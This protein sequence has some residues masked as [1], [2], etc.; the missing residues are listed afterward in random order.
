MNFLKNLL[1][2]GAMFAWWIVALNYAGLVNVNIPMLQWDRENVVF[3]TQ[4]TWSTTTFAWTATV[5]N[6]ENVPEPTC[7]EG[8]ISTIEEDGKVVCK[9]PEAAKNLDCISPFGLTVKEWETLK[10]AKPELKK[11]SE[12]EFKCVEWTFVY[13]GNKTIN[14]P[15]YVDYKYDTKECR[16]LVE[17]GIPCDAPRWMN[18]KFDDGQLFIAYEKSV[19]AKDEDCKFE[20]VACLWWT[21]KQKYGYK[22]KACSHAKDFSIA[23]IKEN[24]DK[25]VQQNADWS[26]SIAVSMTEDTSNTAK[27]SCNRF[28][29]V[30]PNSENIYA[31]KDQTVPFEND[32]E[33]EV[34]VCRDGEF[35][36]PNKWYEFKECFIGKWLDCKNGSI[37]IEHATVKTLYAKYDPKTKDCPTLNVSCRNGTDSDAEDKYIY[38]TC[39]KPTGTVSVGPNKCPNPFVWE[40]KAREHG[41]RWVGYFANSVGWFGNCD[42]EVN[43][44]INKV[45]VTCQYGTIQPI[46]NS[47]KIRRSCS[48]GTP[49]DCSFN[50]KTVPHGQSVVAFENN[51]VAYGSVCQSEVRVCNDGN[52]GGSFGYGSC[53]Q[54]QPANCVAPR[55]DTVLHGNS[56]TAYQTDTVTYGSTCGSQTRVCRNGILWWNYVFKSC[57]VNPPVWCVYEWVS[58]AHGAIVTKHTPVV[59]NTNGDNL[60]GNAANQ[61][62]WYSVKCD[63]GTVRWNLLNH[64]EATLSWPCSIN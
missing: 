46:G 1:L 4:S 58:L 22:E 44:K 38:T 41:Q 23:Y 10:L 50:G 25:L 55:W 6:L 18:E 12:E 11:C 29:R 8:E 14:I 9:V 21:L 33:F 49:K 19:V 15:S 40:S 62:Y 64:P 2:F 52:L 20:K 63:N 51:S 17:N 27:K 60:E 26:I 30:V 42:G 59:G 39:N 7:K 31:F 32:C 24:K 13:N 3:E 56:I 36:T 35:A 37:W 28:G 57:T 54:G 34:K 53:S 5:A 61:C 45:E 47:V 16:P 43:G 48:K